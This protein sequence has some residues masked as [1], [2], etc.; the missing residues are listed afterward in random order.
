MHSTLSTRFKTNYGN[1]HIKICQD[2]NLT[3]IILS[4]YH[5]KIWKAQLQVFPT[6]YFSQRASFGCGMAFIKTS[7]KPDKTK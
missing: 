1:V 5:C 4:K 6:K 7:Q 2:I 3:V